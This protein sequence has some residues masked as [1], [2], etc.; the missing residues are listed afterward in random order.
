MTTG[1]LKIEYRSLETATREPEVFKTQQVAA[2]AAGQ[3]NKLWHFIE[4]FY[5][6]QGEEGSGYVTRRLPA[7]PR[8]TGAGAESDAMD[9]RPQ[10]PDAV[11]PGRRRRAGG[12]QRRVHGHAFVLDRQDGEGAKKLEYASLTDPASFN[13][14][15]EKLAEGV[16][17]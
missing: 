9:E 3:Q 16:A 10:R 15:I 11:Q 13:E 8:P 17:P 7:E 6:E 4:L 5:H 1:K 2:L 14:S 12:E